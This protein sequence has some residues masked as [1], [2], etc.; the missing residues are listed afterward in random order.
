MVSCTAAK[1]S[2]VICV[3]VKNIFCTQ[4]ARFVLYF[5]HKSTFYRLKNQLNQEPMKT[6]TGVLWPLVF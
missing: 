1:N 2:N 5:L 6:D 3:Q 4:A